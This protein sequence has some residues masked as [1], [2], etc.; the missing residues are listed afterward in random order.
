LSNISR[1][2]RISRTLLEKQTRGSY[3]SSVFFFQVQTLTAFSRKS[4][5]ACNY[6]KIF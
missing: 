3:E 5:F 1:I 4:S 6:C 2:L